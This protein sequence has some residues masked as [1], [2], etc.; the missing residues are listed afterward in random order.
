[1]KNQEKGFLKI[2]LLIIVVLLVLSFL[3]FNPEQIWNDYVVKAIAILW[4]IIL[5]AVNI[6]KAL[7]DFG[8]A[9][10]EELRSLGSN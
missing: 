1:M 8:I 7:I 4:G 5:W 3:G 6:L 2:I 10:F 9:S